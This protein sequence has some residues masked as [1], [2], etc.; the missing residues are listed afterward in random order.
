[1]EV[2]DVSANVGVCVQAVKTLL[3]NIQVLLAKSNLSTALG[4]LSTEV[5]LLIQ[6]QPGWSSEKAAP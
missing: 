3:T 4:S 2:S 1:M 5:W 6:F